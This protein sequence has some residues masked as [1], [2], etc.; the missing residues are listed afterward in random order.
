MPAMVASEG[1]RASVEE[2]V[3]TLAVVSNNCLVQHGVQRALSSATHI[4]LVGH[5]ACGS[6]LDRL[7]GRT[8]PTVILLELDPYLDLKRVICGIKDLAPH[9]RI[10]GLG[11][12]PMEDRLHEHLTWLDGVAL[13]VQPAAAMIRIIEC[14][15]EPH[16][17]GANGD[18]CESVKST[19]VAENLRETAKALAAE[20]ST[21]LTA[22][23]RQITILVGRGLAN[24]EIATHLCISEITVRHHLTSIFG[25]LGVTGRQKLIIHAYRGGFLDCEEPKV[26]QARDGHRDA[27]ESH[28]RAARTGRAR[29][30]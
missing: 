1:K 3:I 21:S 30:S 17:H 2:T 15:G 23:E 18:L 6:D 4:R 25:K 29:V 11:G 9:A 8:K 19:A 20:Q 5:A 22:R 7:L 26:M 13:T 16:R 10:V 27:E 24:K 14:L 12:F 28:A